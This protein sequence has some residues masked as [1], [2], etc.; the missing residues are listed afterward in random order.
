MNRSPYIRCIIQRTAINR[1]TAARSR[2]GDLQWERAK[3]VDNDCCFFVSAEPNTN[4][5]ATDVPLYT[6][7]VYCVYYQSL[8]DIIDRIHLS[9]GENGSQKRWCLGRRWG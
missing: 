3:I 4:E 1:N 5:H 8:R 9:G 7:A 2:S 6:T